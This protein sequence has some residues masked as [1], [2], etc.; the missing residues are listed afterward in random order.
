MEHALDA[1]ASSPAF[2]ATD[3]SLSAKRS[4]ARCDPAKRVQDRAHVAVDRAD[5]DLN[6]LQR[7]EDGAHAAVAASARGISAA[8][9]GELEDEVVRRDIRHQPI[10]SLYDRLVAVVG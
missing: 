6:V 8:V 9:V 1:Y 7:L 3:P 10:S 2:S 4:S 5:V